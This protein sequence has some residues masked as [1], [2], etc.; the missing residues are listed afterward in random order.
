M[1]HNSKTI[2]ELIFELKSK[3]TEI[4]TEIMKK[5]NL[6]QSELQFFTI[7]KQ[8][9]NIT[10]SELGKKMNLSPSRVSRIVDRLVS[11]DFLERATSSIDRRAITLKLTFK[12]DNIA[13]EID[14]VRN[15]CNDL[16]EDALTSEELEAF[17]SSLNKIVEVN[18]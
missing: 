18:P 16:I 6:S 14:N 11:N 5:M 8:C 17:S 3:C 9:N 13:K 2:L 15:S 10:S 7:L 4:D 12:G 1:K